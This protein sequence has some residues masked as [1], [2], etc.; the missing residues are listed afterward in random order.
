MFLWVAVLNNIV[1][2][3][4]MEFLKRFTQ[5]L[6]EYFVDLSLSLLSRAL[7]IDLGSID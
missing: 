7:A 2:E 1:E 3:L 5:V 6:S 4:N